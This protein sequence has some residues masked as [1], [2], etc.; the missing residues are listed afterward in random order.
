MHPLASA[1]LLLQFISLKF[2]SLNKKKILKIKYPQLLYPLGSVGPLQIPGTAVIVFRV[3]TRCYMAAGWCWSHI[4]RRK[5]CEARRPCF[6]G[7]A[8]TFTFLVWLIV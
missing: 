7:Q 4:G 5:S 2:I 1:G 6:W 3:F 8:V